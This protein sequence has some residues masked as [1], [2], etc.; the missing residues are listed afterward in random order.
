MSTTKSL[1]EAL[2]N[3]EKPPLERGKQVDAVVRAVNILRYLV[4]SQQPA[5]VTLLAR[6]LGLNQS[7][8]FNILQTLVREDFIQF[9]PVT[10]TYALSLGVVALAKGAIDQNSE[11]R[12]LEPHLQRVADIHNIMVTVWRRVSDNRNM[13]VSVAECDQPIRM[14][15]VVGTRCPLLLGAAGRVFTAFSDL[16]LPELKARFS[17]LRWG[18]PIDFDTYHRQLQETRDRSWSIDSGYYHP[19][20]VIIGA[21]VFDSAGKLILST[22]ATMFNGQH[23][24]EKLADIAGE[25]L[26]IGRTALRP[27]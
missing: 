9:D 23:S 25:L 26:A 4:L 21:P 5:T 22:S 27:R 14:R 20:T 24:E 12:T 13:L 17:Q 8:C 19:G 15:A 6:E 18:S 1:S 10:K 7:T 3:V 2:L 16:E 11:L